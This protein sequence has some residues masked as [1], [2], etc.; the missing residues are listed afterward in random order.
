MTIKFC[1]AASEVTGSKHLITTESG[2]RILLDCGMFQ[3]KGQ[4]TDA[5]N[6]NLGFDP[7]TIDYLFL[8]H[9]H[10]DHAGLIPYLFKEGFRGHIYCTT[11][12][13]DLCS[14]MLE[15]S[16]F[17]QE[18]DTKW[19]NKKMAKRGLPRVEPIYSSEDVS[20]CMELFIGV[21]ANKQIM[22]DENVSVMFSQT[23]HMLGAGAV[24]LEIKEGGKVKRLTYTGDIGRSRSRILKPATAFPQCDYLITESTYGNRLHEAS[25]Q[26]TAQLLDVVE[27]TCVKEK[28]KTHHTIFLGRTNTR[29]CLRAQSVLQR[30][31]VATH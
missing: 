20:Q 12:T 19:Y 13:R 10:I 14:L 24:N 6:R 26:I 4:E 17:I 5:M 7:S 25:S 16:A 2:K 22:V 30:R 8:S 27:Y 21:S 9:A 11:S 1:G 15:D 3:G 31:Q 23:C 28:R 29:D 18:L